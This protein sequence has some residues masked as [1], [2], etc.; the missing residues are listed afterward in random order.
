MDLVA[1]QLLRALRSGRSQVAF[2]RKLGYRGNPIADWEAGR[3]CPT[4]AETLRACELSGID[5]VD[6]FERFHRVPLTRHDHS[7]ELAPWLDAARGSVSA[8]DLARARGPLATA[9]GTLAQRHHPAA[10]R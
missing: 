5:V 9:G 8:T 7:Y 6:A 2:S 1:R 4:A 3:R 10:A